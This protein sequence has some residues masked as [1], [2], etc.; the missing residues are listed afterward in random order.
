[1]MA[2]CA[3]IQLLWFEFRSPCAGTLKLYGRRAIVNALVRRNYCNA[4]FLPRPAIAPV[5]AFRRTTLSIQ[6]NLR[7]AA[8]PEA[9]IINH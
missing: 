7:S 9:L 4:A 6:A 2:Q 1:M 5:L 3:I 8:E